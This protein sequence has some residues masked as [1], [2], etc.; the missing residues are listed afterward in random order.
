MIM[1]TK[2]SVIFALALLAAAEAQAAPKA[3]LFDFELIDTSL[4]GEMLG[5]TDAEKSRL[6]QLAPR[7]KALLAELGKFEFVDMEPVAEQAKN[8]NLQSCGFCDAMM[9]RKLGADFA[10]T[11]TVQKVSNLILNINI[12]VRDAQTNALVKGGSVDIRGNT[13]DSWFRGL[14]YLVKNRI[15]KPAQ[16]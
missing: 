12:Y 6:A 3:A 10:I 4:D 8:S 14:R 15:Y 13:D 2:I 16:P 11:G 7:L 9:A 1:P 5:T